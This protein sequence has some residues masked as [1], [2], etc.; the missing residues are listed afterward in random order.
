[1]RH[2]LSKICRLKLLEGENANQRR[3]VDDRSL[4]RTILQDTF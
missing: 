3:P 2:G 1:L 4:D